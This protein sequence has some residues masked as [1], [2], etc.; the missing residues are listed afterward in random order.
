MVFSCFVRL[1]ELLTTTEP[2]FYRPEL[3]VLRLVA[4]LLVFMRHSPFGGSR[5][6]NLAHDAGASGVGVFFLL[7]AYLITELLEREDSRTGSIHLGSFYVRRMLRIWPLYF[8]VLAADFLL[9]HFLHPGLFTAARLAAF[10]FLIG[11]WYTTVHGM[12]NTLSLPLWSISVE[13]QFYLLWPSVRKYLGRS[14]SMIFSIAILIFAFI[15]LAFAWHVFNHQT[16]G[17]WNSFIQ[18]QFFS[19]GALLAL[20][21]KGRTPRF[22]PATR[23]LLLVLSAAGL[24]AAQFFFETSGHSIPQRYELQVAGYALQNLACMVLFLSFLGEERIGAHRFL[25]YLGKISYGLYVFHLG[26]IHAIEFLDVY[27]TSHA[28]S[29]FRPSA[30]VDIPTSLALTILIASLSYRYFEAPILRYKKRFER[31]RTRPV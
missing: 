3:D 10:V 19:T 26:A 14:G 4:F 13:E 21:L 29:S 16:L 25:V 31:I 23:V 15:A 6:L 17:L 11:N 7:S 22:H 24:I 20:I 28:S 8:A 12:I 30:V 9:Q 5:L 27:L 18:F 2:R 1:E